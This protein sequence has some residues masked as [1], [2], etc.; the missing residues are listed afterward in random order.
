MEAL[1]VLLVVVVIVGT[2]VVIRWIVRIPERLRKPR[3]ERDPPTEKQMDFI[4]D[5][6]QEREVE[7]W[8]L[9]RD[10]VSVKEASE[11]I[12]VLLAAPRRS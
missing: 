10:P 12:E 7:A 5:L 3:R 2:F 9:E 6:L 8:M 1:G 11:W 4:E